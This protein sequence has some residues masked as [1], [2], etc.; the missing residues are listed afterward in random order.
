MARLMYIL[1]YKDFVWIPLATTT[2]TGFV[3]PV[4]LVVFGIIPKPGT[5]E[6]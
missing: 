3:N 5:R 2:T 6:L 1:T 4:V